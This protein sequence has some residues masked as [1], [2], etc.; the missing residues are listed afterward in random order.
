MSKAR[1]QVGFFL[2][3][4]EKH[5]RDIER[6]HIAQATADFLA[7][8]KNQIEKV[9]QGATGFEPKTKNSIINKLSKAGKK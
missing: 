3:K 8:K 9:P 5:P 2:T 7:K 1:A 4:E 6:E